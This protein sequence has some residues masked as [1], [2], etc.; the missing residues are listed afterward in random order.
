MTSN[1]AGPRFG[2]M[3]NSH[4]AWDPHSQNS[5]ILGPYPPT[6]NITPTKTGKRFCFMGDIPCVMVLTSWCHHM[7]TVH[8]QKVNWSFLPV[9]SLYVEQGPQTSTK[10][11]CCPALD[12][13]HAQAIILVLPSFHG[14]YS[15]EFDPYL[16]ALILVM[17]SSCGHFS[18]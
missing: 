3:L 6:H 8:F 16:Q 4:L 10:L 15:M 5:P 18:K 7:S 12:C 9:Q 13:C 1:G 2:P 14:P 17:P 11:E